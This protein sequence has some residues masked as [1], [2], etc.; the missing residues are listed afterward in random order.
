[1]ARYRFRLQTLRRLREIAR[2]EL[3]VRLAEAYQAE[4]ILADERTAVDGERAQLGDMQR[5]LVADGALDVT[6]V[7]AAQRYQLV[8]EAQSRALAEQAVRLAEEVERRR[9]AVVEADREV[10][11]L[12]KLRERGERQHRREADRAEAKRLDEIGSNRWEA[13]R[14]A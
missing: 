13:S 7:L 8:L 6:R 1:M 10:R 12:G 3:R 5:R 4:R 14:W 11:V 2:D 9:Q